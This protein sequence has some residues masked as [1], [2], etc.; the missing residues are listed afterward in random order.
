MLV[1]C[2][3]E[4]DSRVIDGRFSIVII[5]ADL[6]D[7][8]CEV[9]IVRWSDIGGQKCLGIEIWPAHG[10]GRVIYVCEIGWTAEN[11]CNDGVPDG[12]SCIPSQHI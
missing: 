3:C 5:R 1:L 11:G 8:L 2:S 6:F 10:R 4:A 9:L 12:K 7:V